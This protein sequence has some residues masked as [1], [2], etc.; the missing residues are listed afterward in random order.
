MTEF[1]DFDDIDNW[2]PRLSEE[3]SDLVPEA[4]TREAQGSSFDYVE[5]VYDLLIAHADEHALVS[6]CA[7]WLFG[8]TIVA[9]HGSRLNAEQIASVRADGLHALDIIS[10]SR[11]LAA[12]LSV[13]PEWEQRKSQFDA[14]I[15]KAFDHG[16]GRRAGQAHL[17]ISRG[18]LLEDFNH[19][20]VEGS[21]FDSTIAND[22]FGEEGRE[23]LRSLGSAV[24]F[25]VH[26]PGAVA[27]ELV[28]RSLP[29]GETPGLVRHTLQFW[30][31]WIA[32]P[33]L[34]PGSQHV[35]FGLIFQEKIPAQWLANAEMIDDDWLAEHY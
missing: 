29:E 14:A 21:E 10:R 8:Q 6:R 28:T 3:L 32:D 23:F 20:L 5:D 25:S 24:V 7:D 4:F 30:A 35:D 16:F 26:V 22:V 18:A 34:R 11:L 12:Q 15:D 33:K 17:T 9:Y 19:Y 27:K 31:N 1:Y 2:G 13:L